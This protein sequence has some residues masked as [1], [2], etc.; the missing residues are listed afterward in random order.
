MHEEYREAK[1]VTWLAHLEKAS[2]LGLWEICAQ[3]CLLC[4]L[5]SRWKG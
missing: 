1:L 5:G 4:I 3:R 2:Y